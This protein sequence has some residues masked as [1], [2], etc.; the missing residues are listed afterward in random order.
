MNVDYFF[1]LKVESLVSQ[2]DELIKINVI[3]SEPELG[4]ES[5]V[6]WY[7]PSLKFQF[8]NKSA[9]TGWARRSMDSSRS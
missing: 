7:G 4:F 8:L 5:E 2:C 6:E 3:V 9:V 1:C